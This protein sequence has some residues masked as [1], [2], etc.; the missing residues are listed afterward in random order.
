MNNFL[1]I[2][3]MK[4]QTELKNIGTPN[5]SLDNTPTSKALKLIEEGKIRKTDT[6][7]LVVGSRGLTWEVVE[8]KCQC[9]GY[10]FRNY[11]YHSKAAQMIE[12]G[13]LEREIVV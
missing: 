13:I 12:N 4:T 3:I 11:C 7:F 10:T 8:G 9:E 2:E 6:G 5:I 1:L